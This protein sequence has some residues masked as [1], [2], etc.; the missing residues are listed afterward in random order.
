M[1]PQIAL[2]IVLQ[3]ASVLLGESLADGRAAERGAD[4]LVVFA[5]VPTLGNVA[6]KVGEDAA[7][8]AHVLDRLRNLPIRI[9]QLLAQGTIEAAG[10]QYPVAIMTYIEGVD[11]AAVAE[12]HRYLPMLIKQMRCVHQ[13][14]MIGGAGTVRDV[15]QGNAPADWKGYLQRILSGDEPEFDWERLCA[16]PLIDASV[17]RGTLA[18]LRDAIPL[19]PET[20][21]HY[22]LHGDLNPY[23]ILV[24]G[25]QIAGIIDWIYAR[26]GDPLF[27]FARLRMNPFVRNSVVATEAYFTL[28][29][30]GADERI[31]E[32]F[33]FRFNVVEYVNWYMQ[34]G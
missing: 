32:A 13:L 5:V 30:L 15:M 34:S 3:Q 11:L 28:L 9:P 20:E 29:G 22:L 31:R 14:S 18:A 8:D 12:P 1:R 23:N 10:Q 16:D 21:Q 6:I 17:L 2:D 25:D 7:T 33:Y 24:D 4:H 19:L 26:Y 27:D